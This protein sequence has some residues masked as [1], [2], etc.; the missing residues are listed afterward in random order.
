MT[1][2]V[3]TRVGQVFAIT[4]TLT[5]VLGW[6]VIVSLMANPSDY[7]ESVGRSGIETALA[8]GTS[9]MLATAAQWLVA[10]YA[11]RVGQSGST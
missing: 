10:I 6:L 1:V 5:F 3:L 7:A 11:H 4:G 2:R 9:L 8:Y